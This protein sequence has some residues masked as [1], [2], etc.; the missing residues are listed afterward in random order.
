MFCFCHRLVIALVIMLAPGPSQA[1]GT[2]G[3]YE[4]PAQLRRH[5]RHVDGSTKG[6]VVSAT[7]ASSQVGAAVL[8]EGG[9]AVDAAVAVG[10][11]LAVS[12]PEAGNLGGGGFFVVKMPGQPV[13]VLDHREVAPAS[14]SR[15]MYLDAHGEVI[16][17]ASE[18]G[19]RAVAVPG[20]VAG[21]W[22]LHRRYGKQPWKR[23]VAP[24]LRMAREGVVVDWALRES[25]GSQADKLSRFPASRS[26]FL[27]SD[28]KGNWTAPEVGSRLKQVDLARTLSLIATRGASGFYEGQVAQSWAQQ[29]TASGGLVT[30]EDL[31]NYRTVWR[32]PLHAR[33]LGYDV[34]TMPPPSSGGGTLVAMLRAVEALGSEKF[35]GVQGWSAAQVDLMV[36]IMKFAFR[37]RALFYGDPDFANVPLNLLTGQDGA[38]V[39][40]RQIATAVAQGRALSAAAITTYT[41]DRLGAAKAAAKPEPAAAPESP[42]GE[43]THFSVADGRGG[44]VSA[45]TTLNS[46]FGSGVVLPGTG[47]V[48]NNEMDDFTSKPGAPNLYGLI[49]G[50]ANSIGPGKRP[51]SSMTPTLVAEVSGGSGDRREVRILAAL[52]SPGGPTIINQVFLMILDVFL[53][54]RDVS[55]AV[56]NPRFHHQWLPDRIMLEPAG[57]SPDTIKALVAAGHDVVT[58][59]APFGAAHIIFSRNGVFEAGVDPRLGGAAAFP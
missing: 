51:L 25:I 39:A 3:Q 52:G 58:R 55:L 38:R 1:A 9:N 48:L 14:A 12:W 32:E 59:P 10:F 54:K 5:L 41:E 37:D 30:A 16:P 7:R 50:E 46:S 40:A 24:A 26:I 2:L 18:V 23:L 35:A 36:H 17:G 6:M 49:Q 34:Y 56:A 27:K 53:R 29:M 44:W 19:W 42:D 8:A 11:A 22:D 13:A 57:F 43:T 20:S 31:K 21:L 4:E 15:N 45:T 33:V 47:V 28:D